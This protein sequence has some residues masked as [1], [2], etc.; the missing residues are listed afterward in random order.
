MKAIVKLLV[1]LVAIALVG[2]AYVSMVGVPAWAVSPILAYQA[3]NNVR[4][5]LSDPNSAEFR[6]KN[7]MCGEV[8]SKN[9]LGGYTGFQRYISAGRTVAFDDNSDSFED[10]WQL[11][12][13]LSDEERAEAIS[14]AVG[15]Q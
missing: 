6:N 3:E 15:G 10:L 13:V 2:L 8:N 11:H 7:G 9:K 14:R 5:N 4:Y 12:C 1:L